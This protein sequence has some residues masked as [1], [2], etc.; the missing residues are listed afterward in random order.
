MLAPRGA[1]DRTEVIGRLGAMA[2]ISIGIPEGGRGCLAVD[3]WSF[4]AW[5]HLRRIM[6]T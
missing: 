6:Y 2:E 1:L 3:V 5:D 4:A